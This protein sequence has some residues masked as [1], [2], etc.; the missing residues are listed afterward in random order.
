MESGVSNGGIQPGG[1]VSSALKADIIATTQNHAFDG[2]LS[3][4]YLVWVD[5]TPS[6]ED[7]SD[8][9]GRFKIWAVGAPAVHQALIDL[10]YIN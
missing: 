5:P 3:T 2:T 10:V 6:D 8:R 4:G 7:V 9:V 1:R